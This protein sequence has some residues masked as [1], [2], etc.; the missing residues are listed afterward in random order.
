MGFTFDETEIRKT[1]ALMHPDG[2]YF[3]IRLVD[4]KWNMAGVF[5]DAD[6]LIREMTAAAPRIRVGANVYIT[7]NELHEACYDRRHHDCFVEYQSPTVGDNDVTF[8]QWLLVDVDPQRPSGTSSTDEQLK[9]SRETA[10]KIF[11]W[12]KE[13]GWADPIV[14]HSGNGTHLQY[15]IQLKNNDE[16]KKLIENVLKTLNMMFASTDMS[17]D[18]TTFNPSRICK[19]YGTVARKGASTEK[20]PHRMSKIIYTPEKIEK[21]KSDYLR[22]L[23]QLMPQEEKPGRY[24]NYNPDSFDIEQWIQTHGLDVKERTTWA[25]GKKWILTHCPFN[26]EHDKKDAAIIQ[27]TGG[28]LAFRCFHNSCADKGWK[29]LRELYEPDAYQ[30]VKRAVPNYMSGF[31]GFTSD[32]A[33]PG[34]TPTFD[35][36]SKAGAAAAEPGNDQ[37]PVFRTTEQIRQRVVPQEAFIQ[38][39]IKGIDDRMIGLKKTYV[40]VLSGLRS[41]GKSSVLSQLVIQCRQQGLKCALFS[42]EMTDKQVLKWLTLQAAGKNHVHGTKYERVFYPNDDAALAISK[43]LDDFVYVYNNDYGNDFIQLRDHLVRIVTEKKLDVIFLDNLMALNIEQ[44][45]RDLYVRQTK[46][47]KEL[48]RMAQA[49]NIHILFVAHPRKSGGYLRMDDI[50]GSGD[51]TNAA[52]NVLI[53]HRVDEDYIKLTQQFFGWKK[54][55]PIYQASNVIEICKDRDLGNRDVYVP[56]YFEMETKRLRNDRTEYV[57]YD[58]EPTLF[59]EDFTPDKELPF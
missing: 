27:T 41:A 53:V 16:N 37:S 22:A 58:W 5:R 31:T 49:L 40:T 13:R 35:E 45:D 17:I 8:Y 55:N 23:I 44:L 19:L 6:T 29:E 24:N 18:M 26:P 9:A 1:I 21:V 33:L 3:E 56:L 34:E 57:H 48:K 4:G 47:V 25:G 43:W 10:R 2:Q 32:A 15:A 52:D 38:T 11:H 59:Q 51:L 12:L 54:I 7:L 46:F 30:D 42:G 28:K 39:G 20:R 36:T 50:S 14:A